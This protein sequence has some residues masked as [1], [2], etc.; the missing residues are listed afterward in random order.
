[1]LTPSMQIIIN[2]SDNTINKNNFKDFQQKLLL[3]LQN[4][5][6]NNLEELINYNDFQT[7][8]MG[9]ELVGEYH[10][11][12]NNQIDHIKINYIDNKLIN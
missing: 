12:S 5:V 7:T 9:L 3:T 4:D 8:I 11:N 1:M 2:N 6:D 10:V